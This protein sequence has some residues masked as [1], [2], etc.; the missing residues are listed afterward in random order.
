MC[1]S[2]KAGWLIADCLRRRTARVKKIVTKATS[3]VV[4]E[5]IDVT[6]RLLA[7]RAAAA[8]LAALVHGA[9]L[10][11][12]RNQ[13]QPAPPELPMFR[14]VA[15]TAGLDFTHV[16]GASD[17]KFL[18]EILG[19]GG[20]FFD[21]DDDGWLDIF[22]VDGGSFADA[23]VARRARHRLFRNRGNGTFEDVTGASGIRHREY[24]MGACAGDYDNDGL[25]DL[26]ITNVGP[27]V[28]YRNVG[29]GRFLEVPNAGGA[30]SALWSTS[31]AFADVDRDGDL[32]LFVTNYV[33]AA[34]RKNEFCGN[35]GPPPIR[36]YCHPLIYPPAQSVLYRNTGKTGKTFE[37]I[38]A[39]SGVAAF[40]GNGLGV[41]VTDIDDDGFPD[42]FVANDATPN[43]LF[44]NDGGGTFTEM[45]TLAGVAVDSYGKARAGM[46]TAFADFSGNGR[47][48][49]IVTNHESEMHGLYLNVD[50]RLF[51]EVTVPS[52][53]GPAT[54]PYVGFGVV[55]FDYDHDTRLDIAIA[56][57]NVMA[58]A[59]R[60][61]AGAKFA[62]R[63]LLLRNAGERFQNVTEQS[64]PGFAPEMVSRGL[65]AGDIDNDGDLDLLITNNN[66]RPNLLLNE[67]PARRPVRRTLSEGGRGG[68]VAA[69]ANAILVRATGTSSNRS[70]I[71]TR[72]T[73]VA[74]GHRQIREVQSGSSYLSQNDLRAHFGLG[75][76]TRVERLEI[77]WPGGA[78]E[79]LE[80]LPANHVMTVREGKGVVSGVP[81]RR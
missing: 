63:N 51:R 21:F 37:D 71:G 31:C 29:R 16:S 50:G 57:G 46:G 72:L 65:A 22:L 30:N 42:V 59:P 45:A 19:S 54:R 13:R 76:S 14:D 56:N 36:D 48:G 70:G 15:A 52:G 75:Q 3:V 58:S 53:V 44:H 38:S 25:I 28:L 26:Y 68:A 79:V 32:D 18:P 8:I 23:T 7:L 47:P 66:G 6:R 74:D 81:F 78:T 43:F 20:L 77:R 11:A 1:A 4:K 10:V 80:N 33:D 24:G 49:L 67:G 41:A 60:V 40:R 64:G 61:R 69:N 35:A 2:S 73:L 12:L 5:A 9:T 62:Q 39:E 55:F 34:W 27:N 17:Q